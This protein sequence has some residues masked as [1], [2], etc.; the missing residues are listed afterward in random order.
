MKN[1]SLQRMWTLA[2]L[3]VAAAATVALLTPGTLRAQAKGA[4]VEEIV[5]RVNNQIITLSDYNQ[6]VGVAAGRSGAR[7]PGM[8]A[9]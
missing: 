9:G 2:A 3:A 5:A 1:Q 8:P 4:V 7:L 6:A